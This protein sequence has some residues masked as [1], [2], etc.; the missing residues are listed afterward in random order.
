[1]NA[2]ALKYSIILNT[3][4]KIS[5][6]HVTSFLSR[7]ISKCAIEMNFSPD[8]G[9]N[10]SNPHMQR[11]QTYTLIFSILILPAVCWLQTLLE[12]QTDFARLIQL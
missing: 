2:V 12:L 3:A 1:M 8:V 11:N 9:N 6:K 5:F 4:G 10:P 7:C